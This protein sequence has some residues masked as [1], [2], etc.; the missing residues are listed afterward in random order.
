MANASSLRKMRS[1]SGRTR[2]VG[3][4][5]NIGEIASILA[6]MRELLAL[7]SNND[8][9]EQLEDMLTEI[10]HFLSTSNSETIINIHS[11]FNPLS[12]HE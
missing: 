5:K 2:F 3:P 4:S 12:L 7:N 10:C 8:N 9:K 6:K 1:K 11:S